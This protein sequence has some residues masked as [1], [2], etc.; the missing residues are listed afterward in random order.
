MSWTTNPTAIVN[1]FKV[2]DRVRTKIGRI[3]ITTIIEVNSH[4]SLVNT[5]IG[6]Y[7]T[8]NVEKVAK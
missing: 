3:C 8:H 1:G 5:K 4:G 6:V 7:A 2:G